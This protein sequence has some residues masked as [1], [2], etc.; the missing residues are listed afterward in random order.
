[1]NNERPMSGW[2][3]AEMS[4]RGLASP[5]PL[6]GERAGVR[7]VNAEDAL[8]RES[9]HATPLP[10]LTQPSPLP[11]GAERECVRPPAG[12]PAFH[13]VTRRRFLQSAALTTSVVAT[14]LTC[15]HGADTSTAK[16]PTTSLAVLPKSPTPAPVPLPHFPSRLH[17]FVWRNWQLV[18]PERMAEVVG[19]KPDDIIRLGAAMGL[20]QPPAIT[21]D[22]QRRSYISVIKRNWH[23]L[24]YEQLLTLLGWTPEQLAFV[25]REDDFLFIKLGSLKPACAP[26]AFTE[27]DEPTRQ[28]EREIARL[29]RETFPQGV[30]NASE[31][32]FGFVE[33][34]KQAPANVVKTKPSSQLRYCYSYFALYGDPLLE[35]ETDPYPDGYLAQLAAAGVNGV[36]LQA[37]LHKLAPCPWEPARSARWEERLANL[38]NLVARARRNGVSVF[39]YLNEPRALPLS[40]F[41]K[42]AGLKGVTEGDHAALCASVPEVRQFLT[43]SVAAI[44]REVPDL[45]GFFTITASENFTSCWSHGNGKACPRCAP[46]GPAEAI[47]EVLGAFQAGIK[48][49]GG[50]Q[51]LIAWDWGW[52]DD[53]APDLIARLPDGVSLMS[54]SEWSLPIERGGIKS[55]VGEYSIS[56]VG[57]GP[58]AKRHWQLARQRGLQALAKIQAGNTW[59]LSS[60]PYI[61]ALSLVAQHAANLRA[62]QVDGLMLGWTLGG[63][64]SPNLEAVGEVLAGGT[65]E[66]VAQRRFG[67]ELAPAALAA[68]EFCSAA[69]QEFPYH[70]G[71]VYSGPQQ[72]GPSNLLWEKPTSYHA[73]MVGF[74]YD[75]LA[76]WR[77]IYPAP[78]FIER[79][80]RVADGFAKGAIVLRE[81]AARATKETPAVQRSALQSEADVMAAAGIHWQSVANQARFVVAR[82]ALTKATSAAAREP[83]LNELES[84]LRAEIVLARELHALQSRDSRLGFEASNQYFYVPVDLAEKVLNCRELLDRWIPEMRNAKL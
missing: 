42:R 50:K 63:Y 51:R 10:H 28:R 73:T 17:A 34:L 79:M 3:E 8:I 77:S 84:L 23:L 5:S 70:I 39:L 41:E 35:P 54:V 18:P 68:W 80:L 56:S 4:E 40:F 53:W 38:R 36:W 59:E 20:G 12:N 26:L 76:A 57:P 32:L 43:N 47:A 30:C 7:G 62:A 21:R 58:R 16:A 19:A 78:V 2:N 9:P 81:A 27:S 82:D 6:N 66:R 33:K 1:M 55:E 31:P 74:P 72:C 22:Q 60:V 67:A 65:L 75:D 37:V 49:A 44:C 24:P 29:V 83:L 14:G 52:G 13:A 64:P 15:L 61:P 71:V 48:S 25:L 69:F 11:P 45:G 46:R